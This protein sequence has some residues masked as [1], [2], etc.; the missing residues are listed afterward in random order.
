MR[1]NFFQETIRKD[2]GQ[3]IMTAHRDPSPGDHENFAA[4][5]QDY[6]KINPKFEI[7]NPKQIQNSKVQNSKQKK[8]PPEVA[9]F[10]LV[11]YI[12]VI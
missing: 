8:L 1:E 12:L 7:R 11:I 2:K 6:Y 4:K 10:V 9:V 5:T 3:P